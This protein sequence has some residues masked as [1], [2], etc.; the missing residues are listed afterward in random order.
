M[1]LAPGETLV[2]T[3]PTASG[4]GVVARELA[5]RLAA[6]VISVDSMKVYREMEIGTG[7][8]TRAECEEV[9]HHLIDIVDPDADFSVGE[10]LRRLE[11]V[12]A[13]LARRGRGAILSGG[14]ALYLKGYLEGLKSA[15]EADWGLRAELLEEAAARGPEALHRRLAALDPAAGSRVEPRDLR[16]VVRALEV[17]IRTGAPPSAGR[18]WGQGAARREVR[19]MFGILRER[20]ELYRRADRRVERMVERGLFEEAEALSRREPPLSRSA[21]QSIG[22]KEI[23]EGRIAGLDRAEI[24]ERIQRRTRQFSKRQMTWFRKFPLEWIEVQGDPEPAAVAGEV[25]A[26]LARKG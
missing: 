25:L 15:P 10:F 19:G 12:L 13:D 18:R 17:A 21:A 7:K 8:P 2:L 16:R 23:L 3:G 4:K 20:G 9:P 11:A 22:Y 14:T 1:R 5:R 6:E 24:I 26:R